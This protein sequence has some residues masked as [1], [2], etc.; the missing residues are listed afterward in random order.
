M[1]GLLL[2]YA[3]LNGP[4]TSF[5]TAL[6]QS[7]ITGRDNRLAAAK[8]TAALLVCWFP[9][10]DHN[11]LSCPASSMTTAGACRPSSLGLI[12]LLCCG[13]YGIETQADT[14]LGRRK[15]Q[16]SQEYFNEVKLKL[17]RDALVQQLK[18][19][20]PEVDISRQ[21]GIVIPAGGP[22]LLRN[23]AALVNVIRQHYHSDLPI[24]IFYQ[25]PQEWHEGAGSLLKV[26]HL[27]AWSRLEFYD[28]KKGQPT[29]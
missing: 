28:H 25:G 22:V 23:A 5:H 6:L 17:S 29:C 3:A 21:Q 12:L 26:S 7:Q 15:L 11:S 1:N 16:E 19:V 27:A 20:R 10:G 9:V 13:A 24:E 8:Y 4:M 14:L 18:K 2:G